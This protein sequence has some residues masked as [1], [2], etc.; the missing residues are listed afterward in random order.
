MVGESRD[1]VRWEGKLRVLLLICRRINPDAPS[2]AIPVSEVESGV[3]PHPAVRV[4][5]ENQ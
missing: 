4:F 3:Y 1:D 2:P 5:K